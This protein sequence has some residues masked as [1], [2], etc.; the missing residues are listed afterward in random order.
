ME[1]AFSENRFPGGKGKWPENGRNGE[2]GKR[3]RMPGKGKRQSS[4]SEIGAQVRADVGRA[5]LLRAA[6]E[7]RSRDRGRGALAGHGGLRGPQLRA[8]GGRRARPLPPPRG[9]GATRG[10]GLCLF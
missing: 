3:N 5:R 6:R 7:S 4:R 1:K 8:P 2:K 9:P 10:P